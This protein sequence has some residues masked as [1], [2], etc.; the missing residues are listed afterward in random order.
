MYPSKICKRINMELYSLNHDYKRYVWFGLKENF[1][2]IKKNYRI[3]YPHILE[4][5]KTVHNSIKHNLL[6]IGPHIIFYDES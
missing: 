5:L 4:P 3:N 2:K 1:N 6:I